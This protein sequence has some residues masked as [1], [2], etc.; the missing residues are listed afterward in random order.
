MALCKTTVLK[1][2]NHVIEDVISGVRDIFTD[3]GLDE[4][5]LQELK[6]SWESKLMA[7]KAV[8]TNVEPA[9]TI[10]VK[11]P[12]VVANNTGFSQTKRES[13]TQNVKQNQQQFVKTVDTSQVQQA[14]TTPAQLQT[15]AAEDKMIPIQIT[16]PTQ[17]TVDAVTRVLTIH[18]PA[19]AL[20]GPQLHTL[21]TGPVITAT[22]GLPTALA[23]SLLQQHVNAALQSQQQQQQHLTINK[24]VMPQMDGTCD[25][26]VQEP[27]TSF[28]PK[29]RKA[30]TAHKLL[31]RK[32]IVVEFINSLVDGANDTSDDDDD[33]T[34]DDGSEDDM[35]EEIEDHDPELDDG[36]PEEE[37]LNSEDD[38]TDE[39]PTDLFDTDNVVVCQYD[40]ITRSRNKWKFYLKDGIMNLEGEDFVFQK[41]NGDAECVTTIHGSLRATGFKFTFSYSRKISE[42]NER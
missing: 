24:I 4:Q 18:V 22:M 32:P 35:D 14:V 10:K 39:E 19:S 6:T 36:A 20:N 3:E 41:A 13:F 12:E 31:T 37:P 33:A 23:S 8:D 34:D 9:E 2:Y 17:P 5:V 28:S 7:S 40:K 16:L 21:L 25:T 1:V 11:K 29:H 30:R 26:D 27:C 42:Q 15:Q 38:V